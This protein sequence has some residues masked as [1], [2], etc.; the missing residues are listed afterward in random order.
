MGRHCIPSTNACIIWVISKISLQ[1]EPIWAIGNSFSPLLTTAGAWLP[2]NNHLG[3]R[4]LHALNY[5]SLS[6][7]PFALL[8]L[9]SL[10]F[11][12]IAVCCDSRDKNAHIL[13]FLWR[14]DL[15]LKFQCIPILSEPATHINSEQ[16]LFSFWWK[17]MFYEIWLNPHILWILCR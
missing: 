4:R 8:T 2:R 7:H 14:W 11:I 17:T 16:I 12:Q 6:S 5:H 13:C 3:E 1:S 9:S 10:L 15:C